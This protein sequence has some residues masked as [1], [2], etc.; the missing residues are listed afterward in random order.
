MLSALCACMD[1]LPLFLIVVNL[2]E[3]HCQCHRAPFA[4]ERCRA[5]HGYGPH[6]PSGQSVLT[7]GSRGFSPRRPPALYLDWFDRPASEPA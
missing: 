4:L 6:P 5:C 2:S 3:L 7:G 1:K